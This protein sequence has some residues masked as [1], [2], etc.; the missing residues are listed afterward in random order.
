MRVGGSAVAFDFSGLLHLTFYI[1]SILHLCRSVAVLWHNLLD[2]FLDFP[3]AVARR[4]SGARNKDID[5]DISCLL[6]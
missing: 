1:F 5:T 3:P 6:I 4:S 2:T